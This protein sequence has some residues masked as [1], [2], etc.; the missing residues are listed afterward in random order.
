MPIITVQGASSGSHVVVTV[1]GAGSG[2]LAGL[3]S[4]FSNTLAS[5]IAGGSISGQ[6]L[7]PGST[8]F[9]SNTSGYGVITAAGSYQV[10]GDVGAIV[11]GGLPGTNQIPSAHVQIDASKG[12]ASF[13]SV[14][15]GTTQGVQFQA[16]SSNGVFVAGTGNNSFLGD[17]LAGGGNWSIYAGSGNDTVIAGTGNSTINAG[18]GNNYISIS[19]GTNVVNS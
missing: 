16:G 1:D 3:V 15:G 5:G 14:E 19:Q 6:N 8:E 7:T 10:S 4:S 13:V 17:Q 9:S 11:F 18:T 12:T 2:T